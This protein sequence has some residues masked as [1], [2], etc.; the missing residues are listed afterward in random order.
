[1]EEQDTEELRKNRKIAFDAK[2][3]KTYVW[4]ENSSEDNSAE[5]P[6]KKS[7]RKKTKCGI[8]WVQDLEVE[9]GK[10]TVLA[11]GFK[12]TKNGT[13]P[14][15]AGTVAMIKRKLL[16]LSGIRENELSVVPPVPDSDED[17][18]L[19]AT[20]DK[21]NI[22]SSDKEEELDYKEAAPYDPGTAGR[23]VYHQDLGGIRLVSSGRPS[24]VLAATDND[25]F[26]AM[27]VE[28]E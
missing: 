17:S 26:L 6:R 5:R 9:D 1:M 25:D 16:E 20:D 7:R 3:K 27:Y 19:D 14:T 24:S 15:K 2:Y 23:S 18:I 11:Y 10:T 8:P 22:E 4:N 13:I 21:Y 12:M 28:G